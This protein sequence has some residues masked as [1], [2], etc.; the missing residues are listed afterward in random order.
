MISLKSLVTQ[1]IFLFFLTNKD[2]E[3]YL[4]ELARTLDVDPMNLHR[5]LNELESEGIFKSEFRGKQKY[6][7]LNKS[8]TLLN[9]YLKIISETIG[10]PQQ[11]RK[12]LIKIKSIEEVYIFGSYANNKFDV[13]SDIDLLIIGSHNSLDAQRAIFPIQKIIDREI[14]I[15]DMTRKELDQK[16]IKKDPFIKDLLSK[17]MVKII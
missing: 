14:N 12:L 15:I 7:S 3:I 5:K 11:L 13:L 2:K 10:L 16:K 4:N 9:A 17:P 6:Y 8:S 1:K